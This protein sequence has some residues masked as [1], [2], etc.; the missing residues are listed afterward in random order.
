[1]NKFNF[2]E[3]QENR[4]DALVDKINVV[5][6][7]ALEYHTENTDNP[8]ADY[9][10]WGWKEG[11]RDELAKRLIDDSW[12]PE[13]SALC[14]LALKHDGMTL[15]KL[16]EILVDVAGEPQYSAGYGRN[17]GEIFSVSIGEIEE[18]CC[19]GGHEW[20][21]E[22]LSLPA[23]ERNYVERKV[24]CTVQGGAG[25]WCAYLYTSDDGRWCLIVDE[26]QLA[27]ALL[28]KGLVTQQQVDEIFGKEGKK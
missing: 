23:E 22:F 27:E 12:A 9:C 24:D 10:A 13:C 21:S 19:K 5:A 28:E 7:W 25:D 2:T 26:E 1:M 6:Q 18:Q 20:V 17:S 16:T 3:E 14:E 11:D 4:L 8:E 15:E